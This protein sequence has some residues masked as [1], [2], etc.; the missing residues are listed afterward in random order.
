MEK[1][2]DRMKT[3]ILKRVKQFYTKLCCICICGWLIAIIFSG[4]SAGKLIL[5][6][7][8]LIASIM[9]LLSGYIS[10]KFIAVFFILGLSSILCYTP[11]ADAWKSL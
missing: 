10:N 7:G 1:A 4:V 11:L 9:D 5:V 8:L 6:S 3:K 2:G